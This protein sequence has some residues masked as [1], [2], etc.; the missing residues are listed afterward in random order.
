MNAGNADLM[1]Q[2]FS[3]FVVGA[4]AEVITGGSANDST[5]PIGLYRSGTKIAQFFL[6]CGIMMDVG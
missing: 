1:A 4:L 2:E 3:P 5:P 6:D